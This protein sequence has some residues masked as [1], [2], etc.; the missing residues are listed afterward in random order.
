MR[1]Q[2]DVEEPVSNLE[3]E[4]LSVMRW[5]VQNIP[6]GA[7]SVYTDFEWIGAGT[8]CEALPKGY[9]F[10]ACTVEASNTQALQQQLWPSR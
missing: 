6:M 8:R 4:N 9:Q 5:V 2:I 7:A 10:T 1:G 3:I